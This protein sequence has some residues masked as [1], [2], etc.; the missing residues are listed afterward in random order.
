MID[1]PSLGSEVK[2]TAVAFIESVLLLTKACP[3]MKKIVFVQKT[4][5]D[6]KWFEQLK[7]KLVKNGK[8][9]LS[10]SFLGDKLEFLLS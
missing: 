6:W 9:S 10:S 1:H 7:R 4:M 3:K 2:S 8:I 5:V